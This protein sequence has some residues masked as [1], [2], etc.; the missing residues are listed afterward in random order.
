MIR[1]RLEGAFVKMSPRYRTDT[2]TTARVVNAWGQ[3]DGN[4]AARLR[5]APHPGFGVT[6]VPPLGGCPPC[7]LLLVME[8]TRTRQS[9]SM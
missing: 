7:P 4:H 9:L 1:P 2:S 3:G 6:N 8:E 5:P